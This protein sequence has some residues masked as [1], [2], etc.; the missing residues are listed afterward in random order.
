MKKM[1]KMCLFYVVL[2][3][4]FCG[5]INVQAATL[6]W[7]KVVDTETCII[8]GYNMYWGK[9]EGTYPGHIDVGNVDFVENIKSICGLMGEIQYYFV[10]TAYSSDNEGPPS[11]SA[12]YVT[13]AG[14]KTPPDSIPI[15]TTVP[16]K[17]LITIDVIKPD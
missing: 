4:I 1:K 10:V 5:Y 11:N 6:R 12:N 2:I 3:M 9:V 14:Y 17:L 16:V 13:K 7:D 8:K 15:E